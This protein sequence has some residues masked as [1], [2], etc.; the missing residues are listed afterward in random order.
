[1]NQKK[2]TFKLK[3]ETKHSLLQRRKLENEQINKNGRETKV[4][5]DLR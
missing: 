1:M 3:T 5:L 2:E 4:I